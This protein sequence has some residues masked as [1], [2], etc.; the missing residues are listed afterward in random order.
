MSTENTSNNN[1]DNP[2]N[3]GEDYKRVSVVFVDSIFNQINSKSNIKD[4]LNSTAK[5]FYSRKPQKKIDEQLKTPVKTSESQEKTKIPKSTATNTEKKSKTNYKNKNVSAEKASFHKKN[6]YNNSSKKKKLK[7]N[8]STKDI[9][10]AK[11]DLN[12]SNTKVNIRNINKGKK[13]YSSI[14]NNFRA[15][16]ES[17]KEKKLYQ[18]KVRLLENRLNALKNHEDEIHRR[19]H[20]ND[21][22][23]TYLNKRKK[24]KSDMKQALLSYDIDKRN[25]LDLK[26][27]AIKDQKR[28]LNKHLKESM[29]KSKQTKIR[30][31]EHMQKEKKLVLSKINENNNKFEEY[32]KGNVIKI[33]KEREQI[34]KNEIKKLKNV[35]KSVDNYYLETCEDNIQE[36]KKLK[37]KLKKLEKLE[38]KYINRLNQ[39]KQGFMRNNSEGVY[40]FKRDMVPIKKLDLDKQLENKPFSGTSTHKRNHKNTT[41]VDNRNNKYNID[42]SQEEKIIKVD[43]AD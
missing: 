23:Q 10:D 17:E 2:D 28:N 14:N 13:T 31:Y 8:T 5:E 25:E 15:K 16:I 22:R 39:T 1:A 43:K 4:P 33:K 36:T 32:G 12:T 18:E 9:K 29:E 38:T 34:K 27:K 19:M 30:N 35:G 42:E 40:F 20:Y 6:D 21:I 7:Y 41:S 11:K 26:R 24:E 3:N 37:N